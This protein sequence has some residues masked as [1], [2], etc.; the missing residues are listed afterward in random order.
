M[1]SYQQL[2]QVVIKNSVGNNW[3]SAKQEWIVEPMI[4]EDDTLSQNCICGHPQLRYI[5]TIR[6]I[7]NQNVLSPIGDICI[8][9]FNNA[10]MQDT[11]DALLKLSRLCSGVANKE[12]IKL[13]SKYFSRKFL[14]YLYDNSV[15]PS[16]IYNNGSGYND[17]KFLLKMFNKRK[18]P[19]KNEDKKIK[20]S[21]LN[22]IIPYARKHIR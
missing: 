5:Y 8:R 7:N 1:Q 11:A 15:F 13:D 3:K 18:K 17:Y 16:T 10:V 22:N 12:Y 21:I 4:E 2:H 14:K 9:Q 6:N 19:S 20:A